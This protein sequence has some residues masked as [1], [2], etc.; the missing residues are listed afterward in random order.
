M[1]V[2]RCDGGVCLFERFLSE[3]RDCP[4]RISK[5]FSTRLPRGDC[6]RSSRPSGDNFREPS[7]EPNGSRIAVPDEPSVTTWIGLLRG[8]E[9]EAAQH[10]W[11]RYF[12][13]LVT[14]AR[15]K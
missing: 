2:L 9:G 1:G 8:G 3:C 11:E 5:F 7:R 15:G 10:L 4:T 12:A 6:S 14:V 13:R